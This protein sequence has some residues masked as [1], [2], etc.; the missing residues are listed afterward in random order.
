[1]HSPLKKNT[2]E[3]CGAHESDGG[4]QVCPFGMQAVV[5][6]RV[7]LGTCFCFDKKWEELAGFLICLSQAVTHKQNA[8]TFLMYVYM[9]VV[10]MYYKPQSDRDLFTT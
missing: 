1:M 7:H 10:F 2:S 6:H 5:R 4:Q 9:C 3:I 8:K